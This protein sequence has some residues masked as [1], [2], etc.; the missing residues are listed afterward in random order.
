MERSTI[1]MLMLLAVGALALSSPGDAPPAIAEG[2]GGPLPEGEAT[3][4]ELFDPGEGGGAQ[5]LGALGSVSYSTPLRSNFTFWA[6]TNYVWNNGSRR[7]V[8]PGRLHTLI[9]MLRP[10]YR[11]NASVSGQA[12]PRSERVNISG[13]ANLSGLGITN[14]RAARTYTARLILT[15]LSRA[16][17]RVGRYG[18]SGWG[19][20]PYTGRGFGF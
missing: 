4:A 19:S 16:G 6:D 14:D 9:G 10:P 1:G 2:D 20:G 8:Q 7:Y 5:G 13:S 3:D 12:G 18:W 15:A 11:L 17:Y